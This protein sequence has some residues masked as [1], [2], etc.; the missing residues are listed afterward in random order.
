MYN[1]ITKSEN[2]SFENAALPNLIFTLAAQELEKQKENQAEAEQQPAEEEKENKQEIILSGAIQQAQEILAGAKREAE[3]IRQEALKSK[4]E[5]YEEGYIKGVEEGTAEGRQK[6]YEEYKQELKQQWNKVLDDVESC[7]K[8]IESA[9][10]KVLEE[11]LDDLKNISLA[12]GEKIVQTSL[13]SSSG[14]VKNMIISATS[15]LKKS[16]WAK[17]YIANSE[18]ADERQIQGDADF[19][20]ALSRIADNVKITV[21]EDAAPGTCIIELPQEVIDISVNT[22]MEN[23]TEI[24]NNARA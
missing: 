1:K 18:D 16:A 24:L 9:K 7:A 22:Q 19:L 20:L 5:A 17:I 15:K 23:I 14:I 11:H 13:K 12:I 8:D 6:A 10:E 21:M 3:K 4:Q 2:S